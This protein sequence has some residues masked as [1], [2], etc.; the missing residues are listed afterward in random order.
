[1][2]GLDETIYGSVKYVLI[3]RNPLPTLD[4]AYN[5]LIQDE[6]SKLASRILADRVEEASFAVQTS[7]PRMSFTN[8]NKLV[9][10]SC[11]KTGHLAENCFC[12]LGYPDWWVEQNC[13]RS[14]SYPQQPPSPN[15]GRGRG[16]EAAR[17]NS[18]VY[19]PSAVSSA[20]PFV[21]P[22]SMPPV[23]ANVVLT[24][25]DRVGFSGLNDIQWHNLVLLLKERDQASTS[26][27]YGKIHISSWIID[28][29][30]QII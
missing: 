2:M 9:Y 30:Q 22:V 1:M 23:A 20:V 8:R 21:V 11:G 25:A 7:R 18:V 27:L 26:K 15:L 3:S 10:T 14:G 12:K 6:E 4:E 19:V 28:N 16:I 29:V 24:S 17:A 5:V 13:S